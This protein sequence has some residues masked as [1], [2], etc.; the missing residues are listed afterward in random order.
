MSLI[1]P[2]LEEDMGK[3][4]LALLVFAGNPGTGKIAVERLLAKVFHELGILR[5]PKFLEVERMNFSCN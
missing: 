1:A 3:T 2:A 4:L 5:K